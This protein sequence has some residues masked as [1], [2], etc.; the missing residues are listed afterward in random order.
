MKDLMV[1]VIYNYG[2]DEVKNWALSLVASGFKGRTVLLAYSVKPGLVEKLKELGIECYLVDFHSRGEK[3]SIPPLKV[4]D[5][6]HFHI[7]YFL[8]ELGNEELSKYDYVISTDVRDVIFQSNPSEWLHNRTTLGIGNIIAPSEGIQLQHEPWNAK[9]MYDGFGPIVYE[10]FKTVPVIN[11]GTIAG[12]S[13]YFKDFE[14]ILFSLAERNLRFN[15]DCIDQTSLTVLAYTVAK[16]DA[17]IVDHDEG[18]ACQCGVML[19]PQKVDA[20]RPHFISPEP[21]VKDGLVYTS[22]GKLFSIVHQYDRVPELSK[23]VR[24]RYT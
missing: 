18:W 2:W 11:C 23:A 15:M 9:F 3:V 10:K 24:E 14:L 12:R 8:D 4:I 6:R 13:V 16:H 17:V 21:V 20:F 5:I 22:K 1:C 7:W 19:D